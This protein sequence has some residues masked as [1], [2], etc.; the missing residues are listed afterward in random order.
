MRLVKGGIYPDIFGVPEYQAEF[1]GCPLMGGGT[2]LAFGS[3]YKY[4]AALQLNF[5]GRAAVVFV[6]YRW[7]IKNKL[8]RSGI[9][10]KNN[11]TG[12]PEIRIIFLV[13]H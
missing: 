5:S 3:Y 10:D 7:G 13:G 6:D 11:K 2:G 4:V 1:A 8:L 9:S 12:S